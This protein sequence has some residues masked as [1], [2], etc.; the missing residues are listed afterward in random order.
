MNN[1]ETEKLNKEEMYAEWLCCVN[2]FGPKTIDKLFNKYKSFERIYNADFNCN[3]KEFMNSRQLESFNLQKSRIDPQRCHEINLSKGIAF[4]SYQNPFFPEKLKNIPDTPAGLFYI[5]SLPDPHKPSV[6]IVG[7]R[8]CS[9][10]GRY[11][12][13]EF[14]EALSVAG[15]QVISGLARGVDG[16]SQKAAL[17]AKGSSYGIMGCGVDICY[18][19]D[20]E[21]IYKRLKKNG[22]IISEYP[23]GTQPRPSLFP[24]RNRIISALSDALLV[25]EAKKKSGTAITVDMALEQGKEV[26][27]VPGRITDRLS[28]G[29]NLLLSQGAEIALSPETIIKSFGKELSEI[30]DTTQNIF[31]EL[32]S[33]EEQN[34]LDIL[35]LNPRSVSFIQEEALR[36]DINIGV[37]ELMNVLVMLVIKGFAAQ[38]GNYF[39]KKVMC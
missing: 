1:I 8:M 3:Y 23:P 13:R 28:D 7:A 4:I 39:S 21:S 11:I 26:F 12:A 36:K 35:D 5:G 22:G 20:N 15:F 9:E 33:E 17:D 24:L 16:I 25:V 2:G 31:T 34:I 18:P 19:E 30:S 37:S 29:C 32:L 38:E 27:A 6:A 14:G 10:Y